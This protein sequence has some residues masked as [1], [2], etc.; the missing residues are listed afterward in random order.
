MMLLVFLNIHNVECLY[1]R[2]SV[3]GL[4]VK[5][6]FTQINGSLESFSEGN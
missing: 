6:H 5:G 2:V 1:V 4:R 3:P